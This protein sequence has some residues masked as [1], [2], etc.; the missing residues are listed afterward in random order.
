MLTAE[1]NILEDNFQKE[2]EILTSD[3]N[4]HLFRIN[5]QKFV[6]HKIIAKNHLKKKKTTA[7]SW[8]K[9]FF[10]Q[11]KRIFLQLAVVHA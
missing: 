1:W 11:N 9:L 3:S 5:E 10:F 8:N 7:N 6:L 4:I 2:K